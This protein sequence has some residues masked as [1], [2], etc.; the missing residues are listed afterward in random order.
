[1]LLKCCIVFTRTGTHLA[2]HC[3]VR[4]TQPPAT[5]TEKR[6]DIRTRAFVR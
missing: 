6:Q 5:Q 1:M 4:R 2:G 3:S